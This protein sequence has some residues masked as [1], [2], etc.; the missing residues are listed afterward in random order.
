VSFP[1]KIVRVF[2]KNGAI[3]VIYSDVVEGLAEVMNLMQFQKLHKFDVVIDYLASLILPLIDYSI[4][5]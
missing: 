2:I 1:Y 3:K 5:K 4:N